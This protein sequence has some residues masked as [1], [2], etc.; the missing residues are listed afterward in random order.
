[1]EIQSSP[2]QNKVVG[3]GRHKRMPQPKEFKSFAFTWRTHEHV[4]NCE[5]E[6]LLKKYIE[7]Q[8][9][10]FLVAEYANY[11]VGR[12]FHGQLFY[13]GYKRTADVKRALCNLW[14]KVKAPPLTPENKRYGLLVKPAYNDDYYANYTAKDENLEMIFE[15][16]PSLTA[17]YYPTQEEQQQAMEYSS[18]TDKTYASLKISF[19]EWF[20]GRSDLDGQNSINESTVEQFFYE[21]M[22]V[23]KK[24]MI[25]EDKRK[26]RQRIKCLVEYIHGDTTRAKKYN[27]PQY[28]S[29]KESADAEQ[30][31]YQIY[32]A[33]MLEEQRLLQEK[34][35]DIESQ[36]NRIME[37]NNYD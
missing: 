11:P 5:I 7:K 24:L 31:Q 26:Y 23:R 9:G 36:E 14:N 4:I 32:Y 33:K 25:I 17:G 27:N 37:E 19:E 13:P 6:K 10:G 12:H 29:E 22:Y 30:K 35:E 8:L 2:S 15:N 3:L 28:V 20:T 16:M 21:E 34:E 1:M 18:A